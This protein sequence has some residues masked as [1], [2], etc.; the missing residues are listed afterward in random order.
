MDVEARSFRRSVIDHVELVASAAAQLRYEAEVPNADVPAELI[1]GFVDDLFHPKSELMLAA[2]TGEE[3]KSL[4][5]FYGRLCVAADAFGRDRVRTVSD[6]HKISEW[7]S[8]M[9]FAKA[10]A[11][12]LERGAG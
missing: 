12:E 3:M 10:L 1:S 11:L 6:I 4:A 5:E 2:F 7:R 9:A 8:V